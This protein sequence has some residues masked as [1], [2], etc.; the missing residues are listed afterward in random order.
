MKKGLVE[1]EQENALS[2]GK[3][4][5][6]VVYLLY[7]VAHFAAGE[8]I[9]REEGEQ[10]DPGGRALLSDAFQYGPDTA[11]SLGGG[12]VAAPHVGASSEQDDEPGA[13]SVQSTVLDAPEQVLGRIP[14]EAEV[15]GVSVFVVELPNLCARVL[16]ALSQG[17]A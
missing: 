6:Q 7:F 1:I 15:G 16:P 5:K 12:I 3:R 11:G 2:I 10:Q 9:L 17:V 14:R 13:E 4:S 8:E